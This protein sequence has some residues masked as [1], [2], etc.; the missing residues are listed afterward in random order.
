M[1][2]GQKSPKIWDYVVK[3]L[4]KKMDVGQNG[5]SLMGPQM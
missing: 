3:F 1:D 4:F 2:V 5:R